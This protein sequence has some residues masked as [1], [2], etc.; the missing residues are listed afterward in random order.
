MKFI[1]F[2][3]NI[4]DP[5]REVQLEVIMNSEMID[6]WAALGFLILVCSIIR[7]IIA[8]DQRSKHCDEVPSVTPRNTHGE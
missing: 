5:T 3:S 2:I 4:A 6:E 8:I 1:K 7:C